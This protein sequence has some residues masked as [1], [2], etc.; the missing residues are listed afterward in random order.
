M[1]YDYSL[2]PYSLEAGELEGKYAELI[3]VIHEAE[4]IARNFII[5]NAATDDY[6][7]PPVLLL[8][9]KQW[10]DFQRMVPANWIL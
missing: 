6:P 3:E 4:E 7:A 1:Y 8:S 2:Q 10:P 5:G 9:R